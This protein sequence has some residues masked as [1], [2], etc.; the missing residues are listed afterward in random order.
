MWGAPVH[1]GAN[2]KSD[3]LTLTSQAQGGI[4][5]SHRDGNADRGASS[6]EATA[7]KT[8]TL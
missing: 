8:E 2:A 3:T 6:Y 5:T 4:R 1:R 7:L